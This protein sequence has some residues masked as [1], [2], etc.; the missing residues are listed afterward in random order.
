MPHDT[1]RILLLLLVLLLLLFA[2]FTETKLGRPERG[3]SEQSE[4]T[5]EARK[6]SSEKQR[7]DASGENSKKRK[8]DLSQAELQ[9]HSHSNRSS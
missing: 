5:R 7:G 4:K 8:N 1:E 3:R 2:P 6:T 9:P